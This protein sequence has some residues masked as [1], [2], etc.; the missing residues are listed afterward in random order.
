LYP[1][2]ATPDSDSDITDTS[3]RLSWNAAANVDEYV[4][5]RKP[6]GSEYEAVASLGPETRS[7]TD[8]GLKNGAQYCYKI[9]AAA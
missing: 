8:K 5:Y 2:L 9:K 3:I 1:Q 6:Y 7:Y 4:V